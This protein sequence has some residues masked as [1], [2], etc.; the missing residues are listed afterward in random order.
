MLWNNIVQLYGDISINFLTKFGSLFCTKVAKAAPKEW[1]NIIKSFKSLFLIKEIIKLTILSTFN[2]SWNSFL[3]N[4]FFS[5]IECPGK[6][7]E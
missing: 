5:C 4:K 2:W 1:P 3:V 7:K 6:F